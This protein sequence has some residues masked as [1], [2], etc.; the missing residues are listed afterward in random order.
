MGRFIGTK[1]LP[2]KPL[3]ILSVLAA[4]VAVLS[5]CEANYE[6]FYIDYIKPPPK[7]PECSFSTTTGTKEWRSNNILDVFLAAYQGEFFTYQRVFSLQNKLISRENLS[8]QVIESNAIIIEGS[9]VHVDGWKMKE[10]RSNLV[11]P[12][13]EPGNEGL[14]ESDLLIW[15]EIK[16]YFDQCQPDPNGKGWPVMDKLDSI[17]VMVRFFGHTQGG[18]NVETPEYPVHIDIC[19]GCLIDW[20]FSCGTVT[21]PSSF[22]DCCAITPPHTEPCSLGS[23]DPIDCK[24]MVGCGDLD[25]CASIQ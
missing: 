5:G 22:P 16:S 18:V 10:R 15:D 23:D 3:V 20:D 25:L 7:Q 12:N 4:W 11:M 13:I 24:D 17:T 21:L 2:R 9:Y 6:T 19:C 8:N 1:S 14:G